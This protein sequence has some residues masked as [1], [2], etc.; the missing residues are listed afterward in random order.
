MDEPTRRRRWDGRVRWRFRGRRR[1]PTLFGRVSSTFHHF[2]VSIRQ[3]LI[4]NTV[5]KKSTD[6]V[7]L[8]TVRM[9]YELIC[10][11]RLSA[12]FPSEDCSSS[13]QADHPSLYTFKLFRSTFSL[14]ESPTF[15]HRRCPLRA[16]RFQSSSRILNLRRPL[17]PSFPIFDVH[18]HYSRRPDGHRFRL[19]VVELRVCEMNAWAPLLISI[20]W[21]LRLAV[22][23]RSVHY[24]H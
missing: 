10:I 12:C 22:T 2:H 3:I 7:H 16:N 18:N 17:C 9:I 19:E 5:C 11:S 24:L 13:R 4:R 23:V 14:E 8:F 20:P 21:R 15:F 1:R 6:V